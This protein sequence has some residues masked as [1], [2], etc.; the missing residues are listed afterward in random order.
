VGSC[1]ERTLIGTGHFVPCPDFNDLLRPPIDYT[2]STWW[3]SILKSGDSPAMPAPLDVA[4]SIN[5]YDESGTFQEAASLPV[6]LPAPHAMEIPDDFSSNQ[7]N[8]SV[9]SS[10]NSADLMETVDLAASNSGEGKAKSESI[11]LLLSRLC[12][13]KIPEIMMLV[14]LAQVL[15]VVARVII[16]FQHEHC[17]NTT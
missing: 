16:P 15:I 2:A 1:V 14:S 8:I 10:F 4:A 12:F 9:Q 7:P 11:F 6:V 17:V 13:C 5:I 3:E